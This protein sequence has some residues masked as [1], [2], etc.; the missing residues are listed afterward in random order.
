[1]KRFRRRLFNGL[2]ALALFV[3]L[4]TIYLWVTSSHAGW[5]TTIMFNGR[6]GPNGGI[7]N[8][9]EWGLYISSGGGILVIA[10]RYSFFEW[11]IPYWKLFVLS[12]SV[13]L[14]R[15][16]PWKNF[17]ASHRRVKKGLCFNCG[18]DLRA[19]PDRCPECGTV[20][21]KPKP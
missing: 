9:T 21:A 11:W 2:A 20:P 12:L 16:I 14:Y 18:Y 1:M 4:T 6:L 3:F 17:S 13:I 10:P 8:G 5:T 7:E 15:I 19:T